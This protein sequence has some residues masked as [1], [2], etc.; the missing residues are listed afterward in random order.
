MRLGDV[1]GPANNRRNTSF[2]KQ[3]GFTDI[4]RGARLVCARQTEDKLN[5]QRFGVGFE[6]RRGNID[7]G[8]DTG[9]AVDS[10]HPRK[11]FAVDICFYPFQYSLRVGSRSRTK[12]P[13]EGTFPRD[14]VDGRSAF[15]GS[16]IEGSAGWVE[17]AI[18]VRC[19]GIFQCEPTDE[20]N[21]FS[22]ECDRIDALTGPA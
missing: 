19:R 14:D 5:G 8:P 3:P 13:F 20:A 21:D 17:A 4:R 1:P 12:L 22:G 9:I 6:R 15:D 16:N 10:M 7:C 11:D 18:I 2:R